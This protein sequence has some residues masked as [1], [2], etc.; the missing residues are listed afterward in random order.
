MSRNLTN[1]SKTL[2]LFNNGTYAPQIENIKISPD[3]TKVSQKAIQRRTDVA[4]NENA[5]RTI[6]MMDITCKIYI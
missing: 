5:L 2:N 3:T 6:P 1:Q 4:E